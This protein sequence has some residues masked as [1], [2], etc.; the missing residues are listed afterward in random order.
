MKPII[1]IAA[2]LLADRHERV[3]NPVKHA[4]EQDYVQ[5][6][7]QAGG[8]PVVIPV[9]ADC[10]VI[11][12]IAA[13][14][15]GI[16]LIGGS[17]INPVLYR[18]KSSKTS[19]HV[20]PLVD[21][22]YL[23]LIQAADELQLPVLGICKGLQALNVAF[24]GTLHQHLPAHVQDKPMQ[25]ATHRVLLKEGSVL[26]QA[27]Q[28][29]EILVNSFH[30][31]AIRDL[32]AGFEAIAFDPDGVIEGIQRTEPGSWMTGVQWHPEILARHRDSASCALFRAFVIRCAEP[33]KPQQDVAPE[34][35][36]QKRR[37]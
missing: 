12:Q 22:F 26:E 8:I 36:R 6:I 9:Q 24:G 16:I 32:A 29:R 13:R 5:A 34:Q 3:K 30:H 27:V 17:D 15:D 14:V 21:Q 11:R 4:V 20:Y 19:G 33:R 37:G 23:D 35:Q 7:R 2:N 31:Q 1:G 28:D 10:E 25:Q 18:Q